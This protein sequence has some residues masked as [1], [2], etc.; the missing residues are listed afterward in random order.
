MKVQSIAAF[1]VFLIFHFDV[2]GMG[3][4]ECE[5]LRMRVIEYGKPIAVKY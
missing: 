3:Q 1:A 2:M 4:I 5:L